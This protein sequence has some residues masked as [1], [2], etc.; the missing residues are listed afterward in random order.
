M[1]LVDFIVK[2]GSLVVLLGVYGDEG[3]VE[4]EVFLGLGLGEEGCAVCDYVFAAAAVAQHE[5]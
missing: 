3:E 2:G 5:E 4:L 1:L